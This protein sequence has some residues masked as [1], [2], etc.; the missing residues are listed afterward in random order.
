MNGLLP[1]AAVTSQ[2][3]QTQTTTSRADPRYDLLSDF[4]SVKGLLATFRYIRKSARQSRIAEDLTGTRCT[5]L[6]GQFQ[7]SGSL[8]QLTIDAA[9][10]EVGS[11]WSDGETFLRQANRRRQDLAHR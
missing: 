9:L 11:D 10:P 4:A 5:T 6:D 2:V 8:L 7:T 1:G 3:V